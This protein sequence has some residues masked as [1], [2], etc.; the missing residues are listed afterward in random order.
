M[1]CVYGFDGELKPQ[2]QVS[3]DLFLRPRPKEK[4]QF[5]AVRYD[6][7][8]FHVPMATRAQSITAIATEVVNSAR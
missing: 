2:H 5:C 6:R 3:N 4:G 7:N 1:T 8:S